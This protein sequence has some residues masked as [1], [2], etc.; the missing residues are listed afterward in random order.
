MEWQLAEETAKPFSNL[1]FTRLTITKRDHSQTRKD[2]KMN[3]GWDRLR[4]V[5]SGGFWYQWRWTFEWI[6][7]VHLTSASATIKW[8][9]SLCA[10]YTQFL[11]KH[12]LLPQS[13]AIANLMRRPAHIA[14][15]T[16]G[17]LITSAL[18][19]CTSLPSF[20]CHNF[21][22][23]GTDQSVSGQSPNTIAT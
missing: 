22:W 20:C 15:T 18:T 4:T 16:F 7:L 10:G 12:Q 6:M 5:T 1:C 19:L 2:K 21:I 8:Q 23:Q 14:L 9:G 13:E 3:A 11:C 17:T